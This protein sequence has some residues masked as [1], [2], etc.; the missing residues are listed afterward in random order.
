MKH[1]VCYV[2]LLMVATLSSQSVQT[3]PPRRESTAIKVDQAGY[4]MGAAKIAYLVADTAPETFALKRAD[5]TVEFTGTP[6][7]PIADA[8]R[9]DRVQALD[10]SSVRREGT[11]YLD[12]PGVGRS[13]PFAIGHDVYDRAFYLTMRSSERDLWVI[14]LEGR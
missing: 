9:G 8:D 14:R 4:L 2:A 12:V 7:A 13:W 1:A 5:G 6:G 3:P 11:Y 10:F